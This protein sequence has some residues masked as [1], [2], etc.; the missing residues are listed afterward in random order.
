MATQYKSVHLPVGYEVAIQTDPDTPD[1]YTDLGVTMQGGSLTLAYDSVKVTGSRAE[2]VKNFFKNMSLEASFSLI[3]LELGNIA[4]LMSGA[5]ALESIAAAP[6]AGASHVI[7]AGAWLFS[8]FIPHE[9]QNGNG[10]APTIVSVTGSVDGALVA[11]ADYER[12]KVGDLWG[13]LVKD[14]ATVTTE[15]QSITIVYDYTP[16]AKKVLK[17]GASAVDVRP[18][19]L[20]IRKLLDAANNKYWTAIIYAAVNSNGFSFPL[21]RYDEDEP[22]T[23]E[24]VMTG[25]LDVSR[26]NLD[27]LFR[28]EDEYGVDGI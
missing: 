3:Q 2:S 6:V 19:A 4:K 14:S 22:A 17:V 28:I 1:V 10:T 24:C 26:T 13:I 12:V 27:Q 16:S 21:P 8:K 7:A 18:R 5:G 20:R 25:Q 11:G 23:L 15:A 9:K